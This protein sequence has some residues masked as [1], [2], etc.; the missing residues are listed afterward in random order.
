MSIESINKS[1][2][3]IQQIFLDEKSEW[4]FVAE[5]RGVQVSQQ[6]DPETG[7][8][9]LRGQGTIRGTIEQILEMITKIENRGKWDLF[10]ES[11]EAVKY[12]QDQQYGVVYFR[13]K[14]SMMVW[15]RDFV[16]EAGYRPIETSVH[17]SLPVG[18][19]VCGSQSVDDSFYPLD[20]SC[21]RGKCH[22]TGFV[23]VPQSNGVTQLTYY[24]KVDVNGW[25]P[26]SVWNQVS[27]YQPLGV[28]GIRKAVTGSPEP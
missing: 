18:S 11:G 7:L 15:P 21:V 5:K 1:I 26:T 16:V 27:L 25:V 23:L 28:I 24:L 9:L 22:L 14:S 19:I 3:Q 17:P 12:L 6:L 13:T 20:S 2:D 10:Y 4:T 8:Y